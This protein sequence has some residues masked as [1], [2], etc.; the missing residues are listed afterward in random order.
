MLS[1]GQPSS[2]RWENYLTVAVHLS[3]LG[4]EASLRSSVSRSY[5]YAFNLARVRLAL[6]PPI[7]APPH[8]RAH[9]E[10]WREVEAQIGPQAAKL[11]RAMCSRR[12]NADYDLVERNPR[13]WDIEART[14]IS[15]ARR[16][17]KSL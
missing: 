5:Y 10:C 15:F 16:I 6:V 1:S 2:F 3:G 8:P 7:G 17:V 13:D 4:D 11:G 14:A 12:N 9:G